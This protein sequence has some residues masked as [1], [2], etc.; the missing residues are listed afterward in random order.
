MTGKRILFS[1]NAFRRSQ[2]SLFPASERRFPVAFPYGWKEADEVHI[3]LPAGFDLE[4]AD[5][6]GDLNLGAPGSYK[7]T[8]AV[9]S[10]SI[11]ELIATRDLTFGNKGLLFFDQNQYAALKKA[12]DEIQV[13]DTHTLSLRNGQ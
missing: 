11:P 9:R 2:L 5:A 8:L 10:G 13:R 7:V 4:N 6:P 3:A 1:P 12:F